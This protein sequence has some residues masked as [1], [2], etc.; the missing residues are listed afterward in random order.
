MSLP[1][2]PQNHDNNARTLCSLRFVHTIFDVTNQHFF[3]VHVIYILLVFM[4]V[5]T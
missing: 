5:F 2:L 1:K 3:S 4:Y